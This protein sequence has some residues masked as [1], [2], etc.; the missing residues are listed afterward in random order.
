MQD[1]NNFDPRSYQAIKDEMTPNMMLAI[2]LF[3]FIARTSKLW[4][5]CQHLKV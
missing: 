2:A 3:D 1:A 5:M 4:L